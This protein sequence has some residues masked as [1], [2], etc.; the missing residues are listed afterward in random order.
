M[1][2]FASNSFNYVVFFSNIVNLLVDS[3]GQFLKTFLS[4]D[5]QV[6]SKLYC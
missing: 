3:N 6:M 5:L 4:C 2:T 1:R